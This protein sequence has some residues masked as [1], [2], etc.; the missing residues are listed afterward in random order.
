MNLAGRSALITGANQG[1]GRAIAARFV[2]GGASVLLVARGEELLQQVRAELAARVT[3]PGQQVLA[4]RGDVARPESCDEVVRFGLDHLDNLCILVN[5][6]G[7][8]GPMGPVEEVSW[9]AWVEAVQINLFGT[10]LMCRSF[11]PHL[12]SLKYGKIVNLSGGGAT[13]PLPRISAYAAAKAAVVRLTE[14]LALELADA[15]VDVNAIAPGALNTRLLD[16]VLAAGPDKVG[17]DFYERSLRQRDE[18]G[19]PLDK[20]A[21]LAAFLAS[22]QSDGISGRLFSALWDDWR[23]LPGWRETLART[24]VYTLRRITPEDRGV[25][26]KCA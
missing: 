12:R 5:N 8:Y 19:A 4:I 2:Q 13:A 6:A 9:D 3:Q 22:A 18:G 21:E 16:E 26:W 10:V 7:V 14:T 11:I 15:R 17:K 20:G 23:A 24:D 25:R 1:L